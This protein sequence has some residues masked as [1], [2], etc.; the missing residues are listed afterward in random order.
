MAEGA[1]VIAGNEGF[2]RAHDFLF[3]QRDELAAGGIT[4]DRFARELNLDPA[5]VREA[6]A[7]DQVKARIAEDIRQ[8]GELGVSGTP[9]IFVNGKAVAQISKMEPAFWR[10]LAEALA[11]GEAG[12]APR[13]PAETAGSK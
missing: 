13:P 3:N 2:W 4:V 10:A 7:S 1:R 9:A 6:M 11:K 12:A 8:A 5:R